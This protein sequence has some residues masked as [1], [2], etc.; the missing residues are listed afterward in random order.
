MEFIEGARFVSDRAWGSRL[1]LDMGEHTARIHWTDAPYRWHENTG[2]EV[3]VVLDGVVEM[4]WRI[5]D[6]ESVRTL[7]AGDIAIFHA[8]ESHV[9]RPRGVARILVVERSDSD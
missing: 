2:S 5:G 3:F 4:A 6:R 9:A 8:G 1:L 7:R